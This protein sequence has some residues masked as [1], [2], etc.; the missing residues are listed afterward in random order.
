MKRLIVLCAVALG[1]QLLVALVAGCAPVPLPKGSNVPPHLLVISP[2]EDTVIRADQPR[3]VCVTFN[4]HAGA[5][6]DNPQ[7]RIHFYINGQEVTD[8]RWNI[9]YN[10]Y[11]DHKATD[12]HP[13]GGF[14]YPAEGYYIFPVG[15]YTLGIRYTDR[16]G[17]EFSYVWHY[18]VQPA[19]T[20]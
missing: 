12:R 7:E 16:L 6:I 20:L 13:D 8:I 3:D 9:L 4:F 15:E 1:V 5:G 2:P 19:T 11:D 14:I 10:W 18:T 17:E